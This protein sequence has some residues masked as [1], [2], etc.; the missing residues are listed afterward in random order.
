LL[1]LEYIG[2]DIS[3]ARMLL[4]LAMKYVSSIFPLEASRWCV[5][6]ARPEE[7]VVDPR[8]GCQKYG[9]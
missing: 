1:A 2:E 9:R 7:A 3:E 5:G 6:K 4:G 8:P